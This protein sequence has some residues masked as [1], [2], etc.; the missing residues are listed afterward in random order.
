MALIFGVLT[1][2]QSV[3]LSE[4]EEDAHRQRAEA[5]NQEDRWREACKTVRI[6]KEAA[7]SCEDDP[8]DCEAC[9][10]PAGLCPRM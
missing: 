3:R 4:A 6:C 2:L 5:D 8:K 9:D 7:E 1:A 10:V